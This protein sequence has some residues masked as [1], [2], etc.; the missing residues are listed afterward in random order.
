MVSD[1]KRT[2]AEKDALASSFAT[3][4]MMVQRELAA[5]LR[6]ATNALDAKQSEHEAQTT[7]A[8]I[9]Q[10]QRDR[11]LQLEVLV[12]LNNFLYL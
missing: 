10:R 8:Q 9:A 7:Q 11:E 1:L 12:E 4:Q 6:E 3:E 5:K 2:L